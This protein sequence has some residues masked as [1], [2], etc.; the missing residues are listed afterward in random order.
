MVS[1]DGAPLVISVRKL[2]ALAIEHGFGHSVKWDPMTGGKHESGRLGGYLAKYVSKAVDDRPAVPWRAAG[3]DPHRGR[4]WRVW[5]AS[6]RWAC[7]MGEVRRAARSSVRQLAEG[8]PLDLSLHE[9]HHRVPID[10]GAGQAHDVN[11][12]ASR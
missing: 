3:D 9:L 4:Q 12:G 1:D 6:R 10:I 11:V 2:R 7:T 5:T 8:E